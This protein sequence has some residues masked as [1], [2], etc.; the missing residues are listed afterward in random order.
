MKYGDLTDKQLAA[1]RESADLCQGFGLIHSAYERGLIG[2]GYPD[3]Y[4]Q[5]YER[6]ELVKPFLES[7]GEGA[8]TKASAGSFYAADSTMQ[9]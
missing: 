9:R 8:R 5:F 4:L 3:A 6:S 1:G 7:V 2:D